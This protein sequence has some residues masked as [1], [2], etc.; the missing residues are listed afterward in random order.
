MN[1]DLYKLLLV[2]MLFRD[3]DYD[4]IEDIIYSIENEKI[5]EIRLSL[6]MEIIELYEEL[7]YSYDE[8]VDMIEKVNFVDDNLTDDEKEYL[9]KDAKKVL[10]IRK[11]INKKKE[12]DKYE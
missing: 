9:K 1:Y 3:S 12:N 6:T 11:K 2:S 7:G 8:I 10:N 5:M 4:T